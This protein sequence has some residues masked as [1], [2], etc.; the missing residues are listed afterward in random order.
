MTERIRDTF[1]VTRPSFGMLIGQLHCYA[2]ASLRRC[3]MS[4]TAGRQTDFAESQQQRIMYR[5]VVNVHALRH[6]L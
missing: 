6:I 2:Y 4:I 1:A 5:L 3:Q